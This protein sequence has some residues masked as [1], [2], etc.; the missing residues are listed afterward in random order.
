MINT[1]KDKKA[2]PAPAINIL[3]TAT[4]DGQ[5]LDNFLFAHYR[6]LPKSHIYRMIR[7]G[8]V[9]INSKRAKPSNKLSTDDAV[10]IPPITVANR[11][12][13]RIS[14]DSVR[15]L[16]Q[17]IIFEDETLL[18]I[19]KPANISVHSGSKNSFGLIDL[20]KK[21]R[22]QDAIA[23]A[24]RLDKSVSGC[25]AVAKNRPS[26]LGLHKAF[27]EKAVEKVYLA[28]TL[29]H[30]YKP[31]AVSL[32]LSHTPH[33]QIVSK[34][35]KPALSHFTPKAY[36]GNYTLVSVR[37]TTGRTHQIRAHAAHCKHP[38]AGDK[39]YG[40]FGINRQ[41]EKLGLKR[42]FLHA[43]QLAFTW[44]GERRVFKA[45]LPDELQGLLDILDSAKIGE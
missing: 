31:M 8:E 21:L 18:I 36:I 23:L 22:P 29:G 19:N 13:P 15:A 44:H 20:L 41:L 27:R 42:I 45:R 12:P 33:K 38:L 26:L 24:H 2:T 32:K 6:N 37:I 10:R 35:G 34:Q 5:R 43:S 28:L 25:I 1:Q 9:R 16:R 11:K 4:H 7:K 17:Q 40:D 14:H 39:K 30:W 3:I